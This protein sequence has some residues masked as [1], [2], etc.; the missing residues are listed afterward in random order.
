MSVPYSV[1][2]TKQ[3][4][5]PRQVYPIKDRVAEIQRKELHDTRGAGCHL[6]DALTS[7]RI[8]IVIICAGYAWVPKGVKLTTQA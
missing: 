3:P 1:A 7:Q 4:G 6:Y 5:P 2:C 8:T